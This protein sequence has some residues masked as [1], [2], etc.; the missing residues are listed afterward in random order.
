MVW[1][2]YRVDLNTN[3]V[4]IFNIFDHRRFHTSV[5]ILRKT[6][7]SKEAFAKDL[8]REVMCYYWCKY[9][10]EVA[11]GGLSYHDESI[12][13]DIYSQVKLNWDVFVDYVWEAAI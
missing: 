7:V 13:V 3:K 10:Y 1:N 12:K 9:E 11:I 8:D 4:E 2:V 6:S 5:R